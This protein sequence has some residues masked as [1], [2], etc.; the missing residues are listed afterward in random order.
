MD[1]ES[2]MAKC[3]LH[4]VLP[5][6]ED[7]VDYDE[8]AKKIVADWDGTIQFSCPGG[9][10]E[11]LEFKDGHAK[12]FRGTTAW[13]T[14]AL[15]FVSP[16]EINKMFTGEGFALMVPWKGL[17][18]P[19]MLKGFIALTKRL[20]YY[21]RTP[22][23]ELPKEHEKFVLTLKMYAALRGVKE[24]GENDHKGME[25][26]ALLPNGVAELRVMPDGPVANVTVRNGIIT[27]E[28]GPA[29]NPNAVMKFKNIEIAK[30]LFNDD[31]DAM[32]AL[33]SGDV[34][35]SGMI[36]LIDHMS[37]ILARVGNYLS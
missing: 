20:D 9:F 21:M 34:R 18:K 29:K 37:A 2:V 1:Q 15:W 31:L 32:A 4:A 12:A 22:E 5:L 8:E 35:I 7:I 17:T 11:Y 6:L 30:A 36:P 33:G 26:A 16:R 13:P 24:V 23:D 28:K 25:Y 14:V 27:A 3:H 19:G 10:G